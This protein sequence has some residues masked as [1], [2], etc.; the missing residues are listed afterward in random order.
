MYT[1]VFRACGNSIMITATS[2]PAAAVQLSTG[3]V[4]SMRVLCSS[5]AVWFAVSNSSSVSLVIPTTSVA[6][7]GIGCAA[8]N[9]NLSEVF[10]IGPNAWVSFG[11]TGGTAK[12]FLT[13]GVGR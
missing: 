10:D 2:A 3:N 11:T 13:P 12:A 5:N 4:P 6:A 8:A 1:G 7:N 9:K